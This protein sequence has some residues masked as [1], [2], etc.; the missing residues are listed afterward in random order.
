MTDLL[1]GGMDGSGG[2]GNRLES[3]TK[4]M[5]NLIVMINLALGT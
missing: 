4:G 2:R 5:G 3:H 1:A